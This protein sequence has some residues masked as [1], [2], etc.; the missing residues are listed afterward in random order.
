MELAIFAGIVIVIVLFFSF[1]YEK[2]ET[3]P[4]QR[5]ELLTD[6]EFAFYKKIRSTAKR[7]CLHI[8]AKV[9]LADL[10]EVEPMEDEKRWFKHFSKISSKHI[11]FA[12]VNH[13]FEVLFLIELDDASHEEEARK[14]RDTF[15][16]AVLAQTGYELERVYHDEEG[17]EQI[18]E[19]MESYR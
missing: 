11:D 3:M 7:C 15:V 10:V 12:V 2:K 6:N 16:N 1:L 18:C 17:I 9:R 14:E 4:Y 8:L 13:D 19:K 5:K